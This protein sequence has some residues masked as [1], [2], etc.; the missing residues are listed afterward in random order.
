MWG[1]QK[2]S[3]GG[4]ILATGYLCNVCAQGLPKGDRK[5][6]L[7]NVSVR[8]SLLKLQYRKFFWQDLGKRSHGKISAQISARGLLAR[9]P[10][11]DL[12][13]GSFGKIFAQISVRGVS[14]RPPGQ[15]LYKSTRTL[16]EP[17]QSKCKSPCHKSHFIQTV[18][19]RIQWP[20]LNP[21]RRHTYTH[22]PK[23]KCASLRSRN[24][25]Q[26]LTK[27]TPQW[28]LREKCRSPDGPRT[29]R[30]FLCEPAQPK[31]MSKFHQNHFSRQLVRKM[32]RPKTPPQTL[33]EPA[34]SERRSRFHKR[35]FIPKFEGK[36]P[37]PRVSTLIKH[38]PLPL[39]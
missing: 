28:N 35:Y 14:A 20:R 22:T 26:R 38:R 27:A 16:C 29:R 10:G 37:R 2:P 18:T 6:S 7:C 39:P 3:R 4:K 32:M 34:Q 24:A 30:Q 12:E 9:P 8:G 5:R 1:L 36:M 25:H 19:A 21:E 23:K 15:Q 31:R 17:A 11:Q 13:K 33:R